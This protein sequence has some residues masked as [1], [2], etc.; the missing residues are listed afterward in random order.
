M[1]P[2]RV[3]LHQFNRDGFIVHAIILT[4]ENFVGAAAGSKGS[5]NL[6]LIHDKARHQCMEL[7][8]KNGSICIE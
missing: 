8:Q 6:R 3:A 7:M 1:Q 2:D 4:R 5:A